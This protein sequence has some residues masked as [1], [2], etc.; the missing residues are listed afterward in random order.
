MLASHSGPITR[1]FK[2]DAPFKP[3]RRNVD[4]KEFSTSCICKGSG[5][6]GGV[7]T[8]AGQNRS[9]K[10]KSPGALY[11]PAVAFPLHF[12]RK[13]NAIFLKCRG[14]NFDT[15]LKRTTS[16][17]HFLWVEEVVQEGQVETRLRQKCSNLGKKTK[18]KLSLP[19]KQWQTTKEI[20][21]VFTLAPT[22]NSKPV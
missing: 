22:G 4:G 20:S 5:R 6:R 13:I 18:R 17:T 16:S 7:E 19:S 10:S 3:P 12:F 1:G 2:F 21:L 9:G 15:L 8:R 11:R 14:F